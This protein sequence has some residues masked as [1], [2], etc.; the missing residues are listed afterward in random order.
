MRRVSERKIAE[1]RADA[2]DSESWDERLVADWSAE[3]YV[4]AFVDAII[5]DA[6][7]VGKA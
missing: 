2:A 7:V 3:D 4:N 1:A 5:N 6:S